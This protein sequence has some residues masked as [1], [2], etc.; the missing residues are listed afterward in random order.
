MKPTTFPEVTATFAK[1]QPEYLPLPAWTD[2]HEVISCWRMTWHERL[3]A[4]FTGRVWLRQLTYGQPLQPQ[5]VTVDRPFAAPPS[6][7]EGTNVRTSEP[8]GSK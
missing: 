1:D 2:G 8:G 7:R 3:I 6:D 4:L 5:L